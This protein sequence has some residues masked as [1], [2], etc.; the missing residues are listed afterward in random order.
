LYALYTS[1]VGGILHGV[2]TALGMIMHDVMTVGAFFARS[3][4]AITI[5]FHY[6]K[7][8]KCHA[9]KKLL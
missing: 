8:Y 5:L 1:L 7:K 2:M 9:N 3:K 4:A 6:L